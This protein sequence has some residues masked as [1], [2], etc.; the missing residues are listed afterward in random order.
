MNV[1]KPHISDHISW[2]FTFLMSEIERQ[3]V[4]AT[5][6]CRYQSIFDLTHPPSPC[7]KCEM[8]QEID[9]HTGNFAPYSFRQVHGFFNVPC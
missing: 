9:H 5:S 4:K 7:M 2:W 1:Y 3:L 6:G 8:K